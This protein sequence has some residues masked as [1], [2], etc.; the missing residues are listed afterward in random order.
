M[1]T[2][3][4]FFIAFFLLLDFYLFTSI[5]PVFNKG[6]FSNKIFNIT[7]WVISAI[8]YSIIIFVFINFN[9]RTPSVHFN[10]EILI[11]SFMFIVFISKFFALIPLVVDDIL[12]IFRFIGQFIVTD[13]KRENIFDIDRLK[14]LKKTSLFIG[15]TFFITMLGGILFGRYNFKT[16]N[17]NLKLENWSSKL[18][19]FKIVQISDLHL[20]SFSS[21]KK[22]EEVVEIINNEKADLVVFTGDLVNNFHNEALPYIST[23]KKIKSNY[24]NYSVLGNHDYCDYVGWKRSSKKWKDNFNE[25]LEVHKKM[26]FNLLLNSS[27]EIE[28]E[29]EKINLVGVENWGAGNFNKDGDLKKAMFEVNEEYP[30][31]LL[32]HDPSHWSAQVLDFQKRIDLQLSGHTHGMQFG[33]DIPGF[34]WSPVQWRYKQWSGLYENSKKFIYVNTGVGNLAY[35]G[36]VGIMPEIT[37]LKIS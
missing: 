34:K 30:T 12:R 22:L 25:M 9:K 32:S 16:K 7:Y 17:I 1:L 31:I 14:F 3:M 2:R 15:S 4:F 21:V 29:D 6:S 28:I 18:K 35:A 13:L 36:R 24:G 8:I 11:S 19:D 27:K 5:S 26:G 10:N 33:I 23:L 20:G 37:V